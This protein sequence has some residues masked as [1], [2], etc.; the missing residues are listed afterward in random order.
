[1]NKNLEKY[2]Q[3][4]LAA[5]QNKEFRILCA[6][7][8]ICERNNIDY[9][10]DGGT[11]LGAVRHGGFIPWDDD[12]DIAMRREDMPRFAEAAKRELPEGLFLQTNE[13]DPTYTH[14]MIKVRD[15]NSLMVEFSDDFSRPYQKGLFVDIFPMIPYPTISRSLCKKIAKGF[16]KANGIMS[17]PHTYSWR[18]VA[19]LFWFGAKRIYYR[20]LW[21]LFNII[22]KK[23]TYYSNTLAECGYGIMHRQDSIFPT[24]PI[25]FNG[26]TFRGPANPDAYLKDLY[27]DYMQLPPED[28]RKGH[29]AFYIENLI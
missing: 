4:H 18:S 16:C 29:A 28:K 24:K 8:D 9:W 20:S 11:C 26:E 22:K 6:I 2:M 14:P 7:R 13:T 10:L 19:E 27:G 12:I 23:D 25:M 17:K 15:M 21:S 3:G 5:V 1:M